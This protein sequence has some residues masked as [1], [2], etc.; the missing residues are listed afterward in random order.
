M[1][2]LNH[3]GL[4]DVVMAKSMF[5]YHSGSIFEHSYY[6]YE[7]GEGTT[8]I[9]WLESNG[10]NLIL[11]NSFSKRNREKDASPFHILLGDF[12]GDG[13]MEL[14]NY[15]AEDVISTVSNAKTIKV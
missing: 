14:A 12:D 11:R 9:K 10:H 1:F 3:D 8:D 5:R 13:A 6:R 15:G 2:D 7:D 4:S